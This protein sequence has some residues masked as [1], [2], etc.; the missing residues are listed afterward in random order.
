VLGDRPVPKTWDE[1]LDTAEELGVK[2]QETGKRAERPGRL[3]STRARRE[4]RR[5]VGQS[6][7]DGT[8]ELGPL[9]QEPTVKALEIRKRY[10]ESVAAPAALSTFREDDNRLASGRRGSAPLHAELALRYPSVLEPTS[11]LAKDY[12]NAPYP[13]VVEGQPARPALGGYNLGSARTPRP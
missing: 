4:R 1:L 12:A 3:L 11:E 10:A 7:R 8:T 2:V 6:P 5:F 13:A 9:P